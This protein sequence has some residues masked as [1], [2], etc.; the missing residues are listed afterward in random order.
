MSS[1]ALADVEQLT[2]G[3]LL[4]RRLKTSLIVLSACDTGLGQSTDGDDA[5]GFARSLLVAGVQAIVVSVWPVN[6]LVTSVLMREFYQRLQKGQGGS[7]ASREAQL[8]A[9][10]LKAEEME[11]YRSGYSKGIAPR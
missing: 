9:R 6:D 7:E 5:V 10:Q 3:E 1:V 4:G 11:Q 8:A 2:V